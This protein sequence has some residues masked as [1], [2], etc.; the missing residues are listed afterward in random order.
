MPTTD[1]VSFTDRFIRLIERLCR[2]LDEADEEKYDSEAYARLEFNT[3]ALRP[4]LLHVLI[5]CCDETT[6]DI[7]VYECIA[8]DIDA[9]ALNQLDEMAARLPKHA[10]KRFDILRLLAEGYC[11]ETALEVSEAHG[12]LTHVYA[13]PVRP[14]A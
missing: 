7:E 10:L 12:V 9:D 3:Y 14:E 6:G 1:D 4:W 11:E 13:L 5:H 2:H 8:R